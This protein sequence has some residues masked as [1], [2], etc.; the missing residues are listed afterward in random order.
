MVCC[1]LV[2][3]KTSP[4]SSATVSQD[5]S[6]PQKK[7]W[8]CDLTSNRL[9]EAADFLLSLACSLLIHLVLRAAFRFSLFFTS[10]FTDF[11][12]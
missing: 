2:L 10:P 3:V 12:N 8:L 5:V 1:A 9:A 7:S 4:A 11:L 6:L